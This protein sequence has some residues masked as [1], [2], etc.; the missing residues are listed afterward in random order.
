MF[1]DYVFS[2]FPNEEN[3]EIKIRAAIV[4]KFKNSSRNK[5][6]T[7]DDTTDANQE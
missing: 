2:K 1:T 5:N 4:S 7:S 6:K 3:K